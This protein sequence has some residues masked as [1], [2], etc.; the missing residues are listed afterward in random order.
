[1]TEKK[2][3]KIIFFDIDG[4]L[5]SEKTKQMPESAKRAIAKA[6][7]NGHL[8]IINTGRT[9]LLVM[10]TVSEMAEFDGYLLGCGT[11]IIQNGKTL[12]HR[13]FDQK[14]SIQIIEGLR[15]YK[16]DAVLEGADNLFVEPME[17]V[18]TDTFRK[19]LLPFQNMDIGS[20]EEGIGNFDKFFCYTE[21]RTQ[22]E[23]FIKEFG[24]NL[25]CID[26]ESGYFEILPKGFSKG[27]GI[28]LYVK[29]MG[30]SMKDTVA[31]GDSNN[32]RDMILTAACG[33]AMGNSVTS[34]KEIADYVTADVD[35]NGIEQALEWL[36]II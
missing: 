35:E 34:I 36:G 7:K 9:G 23:L 11:M 21:N 26:R 8:C 29:E 18:Y 24:E 4:T 31:I 19:F 33:I 5:I 22:M 30:L 25:E 12:F 16:I 27:K 15:K 1:M 10:G 20:Y 2:D 6:R 32:D 17:K 13:S 28:E 3:R 14:E